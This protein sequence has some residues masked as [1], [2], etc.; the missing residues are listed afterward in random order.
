MKELVVAMVY[1]YV[2][3]FFLYLYTHY[4]DTDRADYFERCTYYWDPKRRLGSNM[5]GDLYF[6]EDNYGFSVESKRY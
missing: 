2:N 3:E 5:F 1:T 6:G 4:E